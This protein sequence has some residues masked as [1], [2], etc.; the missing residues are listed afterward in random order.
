MDAEKGKNERTKTGK[1]SIGQQSSK[2]FISTFWPPERDNAMLL[3]KRCNGILAD[4]IV[5]FSGFEQVHF[6][7][8]L[9]YFQIYQVYMNHSKKKKQKKW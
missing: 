4:E 2:F 3:E 7:W 5:N 1:K 8:V 9:N 6:S